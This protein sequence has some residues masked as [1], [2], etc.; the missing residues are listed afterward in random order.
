MLNAA[1]ACAVAHGGDV[2]VA[3]PGVLGGGG[4][5][6]LEQ[7][8]RSE[9]GCAPEVQWLLLLSPG[10]AGGG[11]AVAGVHVSHEVLC[12]GTVV[13]EST[14][15]GALALMHVCDPA[16]LTA[17]VVAAAAEAGGG[18]A[19]L[20]VRDGGALARPCEQGHTRSVWGACTAGPC[21]TSTVPDR[22][23]AC[24]CPGSGR[25][26][27]DWGR[28]DGPCV[29]ASVRRG[30]RDDCGLEAS[31]HGMVGLLVVAFAGLCGLM[32]VGWARRGRL[33]AEAEVEDGS[34]S[35]VSSLSSTGAARPSGRAA[36]SQ[37]SAQVTHVGLKGWGVRTKMVPSRQGP[38][39]SVS[40]AS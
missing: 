23:G 31:D 36:A 9:A 40:R 34:V 6:V 8:V 14:S 32:A 15:S 17:G 33:R 29:A 20:I 7:F 35:A 2:A 11:G 27:P 39:S 10:T 4:R 30:R 13:P 3:A 26:S 28:T 1:D 16:A 25:A 21:P 24:V 22:E 19:G 38:L 37:Q 12:N 5:T 18:S